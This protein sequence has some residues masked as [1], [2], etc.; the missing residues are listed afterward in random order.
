M[1]NARKNYDLLQ[2]I[3]GIAAI[4]VVCHH[5]YRLLIHYHPQ[6]PSP[7]DLLHFGSLGVDLFFVLSGFI[8]L[9]THHSDIG[10]GIKSLKIF[11]LKRFIRIYPIY[12]LVT[13]VFISLKYF[14]SKSYFPMDHI[15][16]S[17]FLLPEHEQPIL[18]V[19][20]T[21]IHEVLFYLVFAML[22]LF[23]K[24]GYIIG[25][26]TG[27]IL[28]FTIFP[29][30][31]IFLNLVF[32]PLNM[33]FLFGCLVAVILLKGKSNYSWLIGGGLLT[34][35]IS[36][37][38]EYMG[39]LLLHRTIS[40]GIPAFL[41]ILGLVSYES[42]KIVKIHKLFIY[43]GDA[44][45]SIYLTHIIGITFMG[46]FIEKF[47]I[48]HISLLVAF[49]GIILIISG[50]LFHSLVERPF[51]KYLNNNL[52]TPKREFIQHRQNRIKQLN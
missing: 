50:C 1:Q 14:V 22:I 32:N 10:G 17:L 19:A 33:E 4:L 40:W 23:R 13:I 35:I 38:L 48:E 30:D 28:I 15:L 12:W 18:G 37:S 3:R 26:W 43:L 25:L 31:N 39:I 52:I 8:I 7:L 27:S 9:Y 6:Q 16:K 44:S 42:K 5:S 36:I 47:K 34:F 46:W 11:M 29:I 20:W 49:G 24:F 41:L 45:Y 51:L 2:L 21:L